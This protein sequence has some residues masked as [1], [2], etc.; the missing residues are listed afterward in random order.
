[1]DAALIPL[2]IVAV[3]AIF[4]FGL[5]RQLRRPSGWVG[6]RLMGKALNQGNRRMLDSAVEALAPVEGESIVD[7]GFGGGYALD[8][9]RARVAPARPAGIEISSAMIEAARGRWGDA[10][11][12]HLADV[13]SM[14]FDDRTRDGV[15]SVNSIY[16]WPDPGAALRE[17]RR[18]LKPGGRVVFGIRRRDIMWFSPVTWFGFR[19]YSVDRVKA[20]L[21][22]A[23]FSVEVREHDWGELIVLGRPE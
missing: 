2:G 18:V 11:E 23:G 15:L 8:V 13:A 3:L 17:I 5:S 19:M 1:M 20:L 14:P 12:L 10:V 9:I 21:R 22:A 6:R 7:V 4:C 16:F